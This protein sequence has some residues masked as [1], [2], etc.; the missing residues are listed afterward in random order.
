MLSLSLL[1]LLVA[2][3]A[4]SANHVQPGVHQF[5]HKRMLDISGL[6]GVV[7]HE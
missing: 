7:N 6:D 5:H 1:S 2:S 4:V 3:S